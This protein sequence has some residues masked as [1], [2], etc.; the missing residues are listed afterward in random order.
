MSTKKYLILFI[1]LVVSTFIFAQS[2]EK[3]T[4]Q[5][6]EFVSFFAE[7]M[8]AIKN[9]IEKTRVASVVQLIEDRKTNPVNDSLQ[10]ATQ[11]IKDS[12]DINVLLSEY[13][14]IASRSP[15]IE[16]SDLEKISVELNS[17]YNLL[18]NRKLSNIMVRPLR[19]IKNKH[20][21]QSMITAQRKNTL[22]VFDKTDPDRILNYMLFI[23]GDIVKSK[24][25]RILGWKLCFSHGVYYY[26]DF[27]GMRGLDVFFIEVRAPEK[28]LSRL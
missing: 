16:N 23:P 6:K 22:A 5:E 8:S 10:A 26:E 14:L 28:P 27:I 11:K 15:Y 1:L 2:N 19:L 7:F 17:F 3:L 20:V 13:L 24:K 25:P 21:Y 4:E 12:V 18:S 9:K